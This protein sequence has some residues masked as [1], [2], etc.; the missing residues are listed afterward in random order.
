VRSCPR[1]SFALLSC[2]LAVFQGCSGCMTPFRGQPEK[3]AAAPPLDAGA[4]DEWDHPFGV[5][6]YIPMVYF[7][8]EGEPEAH[9]LYPSAVKVVPGVPDFEAGLRSCSGVIV[10]PRVILTA[11]HSVCRQRPADVLGEARGLRVDGASCIETASVEVFFYQYHPQALQGITRTT[12]ARFQGKVRP[13]PELDIQLDA[14]GRVLLGHA[15]LALVV[16]D[17]PVPPGFTPVRLSSI[18]VTAQ[19]NLVTVGFGHDESR[20]WLDSTRLINLR[21]A[22]AAVDA[23]WGRFQFEQ[24]RQPFFRG[25]SGG[26]C[27]RQ[28]HRGPELVGISTTGL[29]LQPTLT[30]LLPYREWLL[31]EIGRPH[32]TSVPERDKGVRL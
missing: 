25:D 27:F 2:L 14:E 4:P 8:V 26:P 10:A 12:S 31:Q 6:A 22:V 9:N 19:D 24:D 17:T 18:G 16:L 20:G 3:T 21:K 30:A 23:P 32:T 7:R 5:N 13:H 11:A 29:G 1:A 15:D 28:S